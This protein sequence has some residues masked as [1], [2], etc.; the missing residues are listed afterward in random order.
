L[1]SVNFD[2]HRVNFVSRVKVLQFWWN[3]VQWLI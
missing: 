3:L 1:T 2:R